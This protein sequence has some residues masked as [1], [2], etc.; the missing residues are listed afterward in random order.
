[1]N[2]LRLS[3]PD[4]A[5]LRADLLRSDYTF[6]QVTDRLGPVATEAL[7]RN[8]SFA[9]RRA[10][11]E[12]DDPQA[13]AIRL[14]LLA[15]P[16]PAARVKYW[17]SFDAL[18][19]AGLLTFS[20][21]P[22]SSE[23][24]QWVRA[25]VELKPHASESHHGWICSDATPLDGRIEQPRPDFVLGASPASTTL[26][27]LVP[28]Q[29]WGSVLDLG[30]GCGIQALHLDADRIVATDL[31]PRALVLATISLGLSQVAADLRLGSLYEPVAD[32][33]FDLILTNPPYV[34]AP[35]GGELVYREGGFAGDD[36]MR[37][38]VSQAADHLSDNGLLVVLGNW[39]H[40]AG[41]TWQ[42][43][44][45]TW[46]PDGCDA[47]ILQREQLDPDAYIDLWLADAGLSGNP[48][49]A[50]AHRRWADYFDELQLTA[51]GMGW[52]FLRKSGR[53][54]PQIRI[55]EWVHQ[56]AQ[57]V[58]DAIADYF[59]AID[60]AEAPDPVLLTS[61]LVCA[62]SVTQET[63]GRPGAADPEHIV[64]R[65]A[66]G[67]CRAVRVDTALAALVGAC[68]A[69]LSVGALI[70]VIA[71]LLERSQTE[72]IVEILPRIRQLIADGFLTAIHRVATADASDSSRTL[73]GQQ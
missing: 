29:H 13:D 61:H 12:S 72:L 9:V 41:Q 73:E 7:G 68:D 37:T 55:E 23:P 17:R 40:L 44:L 66:T 53:T 16:L 3:P 65:Q 62:D 51:V 48:E 52:L 26:A 25:S 8:S 64:L 24:G 1:M 14:W 32:E 39:A 15:D 59:N 50:A 31:N 19:S 35:P 46:I 27:Q 33:R 71:G 54:T 45:K 38:V 47:L 18:I 57:P 36:L 6:D 21:P 5:A 60:L 22:D 20:A 10:L 70:G 30:T 11:G 2:S 69:D 34:I 56:V 49:Q 42:D 58:G 63:Y 43:R 67:L 28:Q 4:L